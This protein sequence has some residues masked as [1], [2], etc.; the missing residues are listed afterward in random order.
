VNGRRDMPPNCVLLLKLGD[1]EVVVTVHAARRWALR[2]RA[3]ERRRLKELCPDIQRI[4]AACAT[5]SAEAPP[6]VKLNE[7]DGAQQADEW[8]M[9]GPDIAMPLRGGG[10]LDDARS[11]VAGTGGTGVAQ[12][13]TSGACCCASSV[14][15]R[16]RPGTQVGGQVPRVM[17]TAN[18][19]TI[20][21]YPSTWRQRWMRQ[22][23]RSARVRF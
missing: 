14:G 17:A 5:F 3:D 19:V 12:A 23:T 9:F 21:A 22:V 16:R 7:E 8:L 15:E 11:C 4:A 2:V 6:W 18:A 13:Q 1:R 20:R 10:R